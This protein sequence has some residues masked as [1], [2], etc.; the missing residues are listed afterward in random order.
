MMYAV[1]YSA[2]LSTNKAK[3][4]PVFAPIAATL[5]SEAEIL[6]VFML[7]EIA[8]GKESFW[9]VYFQILEHPTLFW[10][11]GLAEET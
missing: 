7:Y 5:D 4:D 8:K 2:M 11:W 10:T 6:A 9:H 1:P 3:T